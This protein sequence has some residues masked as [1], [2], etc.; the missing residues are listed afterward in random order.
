MVVKQAI[1]GSKG[2]DV[3]GPLSSSQAL[4]MKSSGYDFCIRYIPRTAALWDGNITA[5]EMS[6]IL[7][8]GLALSIVQ[9][10]AMSPWYPNA[11]IGSEYGEYAGIYAKSIGLPEGIN[12]WLDLEEVGD[13]H[14]QDI[15]NYCN[16]WFLEVNSAGYVPGIYVGWQTGLSDQQLYDLPFAHYWAAYNCDQTIPTRGFQMRQSIQK[17][18]NGVEFDP[19]TVTP[20]QLGGLPIF[21]FSA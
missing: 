20:D 1:A 12:I 3:D 9:H 14:S 15:I 6:R 13:S 2:F 16:N 8:A 5:S 19:N 18:L 7:E 17:T 10:V 21:L 11:A 4:A